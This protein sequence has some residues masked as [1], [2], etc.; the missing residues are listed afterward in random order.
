MLTFAF[1][2]FQSLQ[3]AWIKTELKEI[4]LRYSNRTEPGKREG[5]EH[6]DFSVQIPWIGPA[7]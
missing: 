7:S 1:I 3:K 5:V 4:K 6:G 2:S